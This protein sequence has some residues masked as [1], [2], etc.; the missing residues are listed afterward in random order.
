[1]GATLPAVSIAP[2]GVLRNLASY[3]PG[4]SIAEVKRELGLSRVVKL[5]SNENPLGS[6]PRARTAYRRAAASLALYPEGT[7]P[8]LR[9]AL[10]R[11]HRVPP[12]SVII[13]N[14][15]DEIIRLL[16]ET[17]LGP[18]DEAVLSQYGFL[19]FRQQA[20]LMGA[21]LREVPMSHWTHDLQA[22]AR[23]A[24]PA[25]KIIF[26]ANPNN[27][28]GTHN[29]A[30]EVEEFVRAVP[31]HALLVF[32][33]A[34]ESYARV[35][36]SYP[37][38][39]PA[40]VTKNPNCVVLR[41]FSKAHGLAALRVGYGVARPEVIGWLDRARMPFNVSL[42]AQ[43]A[44]IAALGDKGFVRKSVGLVNRERGPLAAALRGRGFAVEEPSANFLFARS[45]LHG[46]E[47]FSKLL[48]QGVIVR[49]L[50]EYGLEDHVRITVG[51]A[52]QNKALVRAIDNVLAETRRRDA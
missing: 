25:T 45:P 20:A 9:E 3:V 37:D 39:L 1:M 27:P 48:R 34:Y 17:F 10:E 7:S 13:G 40:L 42:P 50:G 8:L 28:T 16:C 47:L 44:C 31:P 33:E 18:D 2:R 21:R 15:S 30:R 5:A 14:G 51:A 4:K 29:T 12:G 24:G 43:E 38:S 36:P 11:F 35:F 19:R 49:P 46:A 52:S 22:M 32:D 41:T 26:V 6:S 23:A